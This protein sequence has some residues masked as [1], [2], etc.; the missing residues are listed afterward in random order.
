M[1]A[2]KT[3][4]VALLTVGVALTGCF[5]PTPDGSGG[6]AGGGVAGG[7]G[8]GTAGGAGIGGGVG[9][10]A[11]VGGGSGG[12]GAQQELTLSLSPAAATLPIG[13]SQSFVASQVLENGSV[14]DVTHLV[15]WAAEPADV[16][17]VQAG[18][19]KALKAGNAR[20][21]ATIGT[22][23]A[24]AQVTV[25]AATLVKI[26]L[27][28]AVL[29]LRPGATGSLW[30]L[31][32]LSDSSPIDVT[33]QATFTSSSPAV[34]SAGPGGQV[35]GLAPGMA[36]I[37]ATVAGLTSTA[38]VTVSAAK[39]TSITVI[40]STASLPIGS[41]LLFKARGGFDDNSQ[42]DISASV[43]WSSGSPAVQIAADGMAIGISA[44]TATI[45]ALLAGQA[46]TAS[47]TVAAAT[48]VKLELG[49]AAAALALTA[50][51]THPLIATGTFSDNTTL[52]LTQAAA[53]LSADPSTAAVSN[54]AGARGL[55]S[56]LKPG[57]TEI[58]ARI[59]T[60]TGKLQVVVAASP[61]V[62]LTLTPPAAT[63][64]PGA[65]QGF[66]V[67]GKFADNSTSDLTQSA[68]WS[69]SDATIVSVS[70]AAGSRGEATALKAG[71][72]QVRASFGGITGTAQLTVNQA[73]VADGLTIA[74]ATVT[75]EA[76]R[77]I[78]VK[79]M[80]HYTDGSLK[81]VSELSV[82]TSSASA[83]ASVSNS[84]GI[85]GQVKGL[86]NG[87]TTI[88]ATFGSFV[89]T[90]AVTVSPPVVV[91]LN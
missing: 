74:P 68:V 2:R 81:D 46:G 37:T 26:E 17:T 80:A 39:L 1:N 78:G 50:G 23:Q 7:S 70:N 69:S 67:T 38:Q 60:I 21:V 42:A 13:S 85:K 57:S 73:V 11:A 44:G 43:V 91:A 54:A 25:P 49:P 72:A 53:W 65:K 15:S 34:V 79:A 20:L 10:G 75:I 28:P 4:L 62:S 36:T 90:G 35:R 61:L 82:W 32:T 48:L 9:G 8:G 24:S 6:G 12:G 83:F 86:A 64:A 66:T 22:L 63:V 84:T 59:G 27:S 52:E 88:P 41:T 31:G 55:V 14:L 40:P 71:T 29:S 19:A 87:S 58:S 89:A 18:V 3:W 56:A 47:V 33:A 5:K 51:Q 76:G 16:L 45:T 30:V 77:T